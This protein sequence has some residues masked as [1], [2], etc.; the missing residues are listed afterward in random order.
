MII[1]SIKSVQD[2]V[3]TL[4]RVSSWVKQ[5]SHPTELDFFIQVN[6]SGYLSSSGEIIIPNLNVGDRT[7]GLESNFF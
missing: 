5:Y 1:I 2:H 6:S 3:Y 7:R 4:G